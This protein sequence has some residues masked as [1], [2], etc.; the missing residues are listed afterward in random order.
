MV[1]LELQVGESGSLEYLFYL[2]ITL[3][4][5]EYNAP[6]WDEALPALR[7]REQGIHKHG[8]S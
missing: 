2:R 8:L 5:E 3:E 6:Q 7:E 4:E 1:S